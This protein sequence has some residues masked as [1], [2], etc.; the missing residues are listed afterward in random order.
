M[1]F[2][3]FEGFSLKVKKGFSPTSGQILVTFK[4]SVFAELGNDKRGIY[5]GILPG[6]K[7]QFDTAIISRFF[8]VHRDGQKVS[9]GCVIPLPLVAEASSRTPGVRYI[10]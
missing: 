8:Y 6:G 3:I 4:R 2:G 9:L 1:T 7:L 10:K 5:A